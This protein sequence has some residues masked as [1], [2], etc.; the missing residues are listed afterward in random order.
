MSSRGTLRGQCRCA[1]EDEDFFRQDY[2][3]EDEE[4][5]Y[6][7]FDM[8]SNLLTSVSVATEDGNSLLL[9][10]LPTRK[11]CTFVKDVDESMMLGL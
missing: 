2:V 4:S 6:I 8:V 11:R 3:N 9:T 1:Y 5:N 7:P 10:V